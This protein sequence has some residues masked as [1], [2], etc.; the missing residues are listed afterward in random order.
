LFSVKL[1]GD[2]ELIER[3]RSMP[4]RV[5]AAL[6]KRVSALAVQLADRVRRKLSGEV[7][8]VRTGNLRASIF[9]DVEQTATSVVGRVGSSG[10][11]K[12]S[13]IHE[14]GGTIPAHEVVPVKAQALSFIMGGKRVFFRR[15]QIPA[16]QMPERSYL[17]SSLEEMRPAIVAG[18]QEAAREGVQEK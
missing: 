9:E 14:Y 12:Y 5:R 16:I 3:L 8:N 11:V 7:L 2:R 13:R 1:E 6:L 17:R 10:D 18:L 15:V 4:D